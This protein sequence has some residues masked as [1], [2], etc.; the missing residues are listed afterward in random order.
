M[1]EEIARIRLI[2]K[3]ED[4]I[5]PNRHPEISSVGDLLDMIERV[6][7]VTGKPVGIKFVLGSQQWLFD[8]CAE[9]ARRGVESALIL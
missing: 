6:R 3:G 2:N 8:L 1:T 9:I 7:N 5:S 4:S